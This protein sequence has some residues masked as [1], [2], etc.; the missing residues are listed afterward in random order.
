MESA[1][2]KS[3]PSLQKKTAARMAAVQALYTQSINETRVS[4]S[5]QVTGLKKQLENNRDEQKLQ[6]GVALEPN[7]K[8]LETIL[9]GVA[10]RNDDIEVRIKSV[11]SG[12]WKQERMSPLLLAILRCAIFEMIFGKDIGAK[13]VIDEYTR[14]TRSFFT[15]SEVNFVHGALSKLAESHG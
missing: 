11:L 6:V 12:S 9:E 5:Q 8:L 1:A 14:L 10:E 4:P 15:Y 13:I 7:Y 2:A 3:N